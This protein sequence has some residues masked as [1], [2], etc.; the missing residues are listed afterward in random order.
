V[1]TD[2][3]DPDIFVYTDRQRG[4]LT[5]DNGVPIRKDFEPFEPS[6]QRSDAWIETPVGEGEPNHPLAVY[7]TKKLLNRNGFHDFRPGI[8]Q[9]GEASPRFLAGLKR[10]Q[11]MH[12]LKPDAMAW[13]GGPT[14]HMLLRKAFGEGDGPPPAVESGLFKDRFGKDPNRTLSGQPIFGG[15]GSEGDGAELVPA[16]FKIPRRPKVRPK[17]SPKPRPRSEG[18]GGGDRKPPAGSAP[19]G[20]R[21]RPRPEREPPRK[22]KRHEHETRESPHPEEEHPV[23]VDRPAFIY[24]YPDGRLYASIRPNGDIGTSSKRGSAHFQRLHTNVM[25]KS[26]NN[27]SR[28]TYPLLE[29]NRSFE[30]RRVA[31]EE[32]YVRGE[33]LNK[34]GEP[35]AYTILIDPDS[36]QPLRA[37][38]GKDI[39]LNMDQIKKLGLTLWHNPHR[40][41]M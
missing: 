3:G 15:E 1:R 35:I 12:D 23:V 21:G 4:R 7:K 22:K 2:F 36:G 39:Y 33:V 13:P 41:S 19:P 8:E 14:V 25:I 31:G 6:V 10:F 24:R 40:R 16:K 38:V 18:D 17:P 32:V 37:P 29:D 26:L 28:R 11:A 27:S 34:H 9:M 30:Q 5:D 20:E